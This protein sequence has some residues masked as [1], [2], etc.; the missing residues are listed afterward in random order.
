M[1]FAWIGQS[2]Y[3]EPAYIH[4]RAN[5]IQCVYGDDPNFASMMCALTRRNGPLAQPKPD[6]CDKTWGLSYYLEE[7]GP[8]E[9]L[10][11]NKWTSNW[12]GNG[13]FEVGAPTQADAAISCK[14]TRNTLTC[15]NSDGHGFYL[16]R[17]EQRLF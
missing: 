5:N 7:R 8:V 16:S 13:K 6:D 9:M 14:A 2:A 11:L 15:T 10:C 4:T 17:R 1:A 3:A 12:P